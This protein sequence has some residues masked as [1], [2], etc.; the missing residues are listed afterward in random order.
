[1][2]ARLTRLPPHRQGDGQ[3]P[4]HSAAK[5]STSHEVVEAL[6]R[7]HPDGLT[8]QDYVSGGSIARAHALSLPAPIT[9]AHTLLP[10]CTLA[11]AANVSPA[12]AV[13]PPPGRLAGRPSSVLLATPASRS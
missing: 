6:I 10:A 7:A 3:L 12:V 11:L 2:R 4:L 1:M 5:I 13:A 9:R 8:A